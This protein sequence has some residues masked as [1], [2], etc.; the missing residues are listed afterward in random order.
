M[1]NGIIYADNAATTS[2]SPKALEAMLPFLQNQYGNAS[3]P[4]S[5]SRSV[6]KALMVSRE[7]IADCMGASPDEIYFTS[8]GSEGNNWII[9][10]AT[11]LQT[12]IV[13]STIE[14]HSIL[15]AA[16]YS[17]SIGIDV[18]YLPASSTGIVEIDA[19]LGQLSQPL[20]LVSVMFVNNE[21]GSIQKI[22]ELARVTHERGSLFHTD[23]VQCVGHLDLNVKALDIDMLTASAHKFN[24]PKGIGFAYIKKGIK[25]PNLIYG[26]S[27]E[28]GL[29]AGTENVAS[30]VGM[31]EALEE[32]VLNIGENI[33]HCRI[34]ETA[35][36]NRLDSSG[37][38]YVRNGESHLPGIISL[39]FPGFEGE[40]LLHR[41][42]LMGIMVST[43]SACDSKNLQIS[44]VLKAIK[45]DE[46]LAKGTI[47][48]SLGHLNTEK[49]VIRI[50]D[51]LLK[52]INSM[53]HVRESI[54]VYNSWGEDIDEILKD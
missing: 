43:G 12:K 16:E 49:E 10:G 51:A 7:R 45:M 22:A 54:Q 23:A 41:L 32:N 39:S 20:S 34:L 38:R 1:S 46:N 11:Q 28:F 13:T 48:I 19:L 18:S 44:H 25:W 17:K 40:L 3:Q 9:N 29:R 42:D 4:Y 31:A 24:G 37:I 36:I 50:A 5:F 26:G 35:L 47:R 52:I 21:I 33:R 8:G 30:I 27:Q 6:R 14:H 2:L 15:R 53:S